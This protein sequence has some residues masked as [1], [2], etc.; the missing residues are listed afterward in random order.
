MDDILSYVC[1][2]NF[3]APT[4]IN[5]SKTTYEDYFYEHNYKDLVSS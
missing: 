3:K 1:T 4:Q 2:T 5:F